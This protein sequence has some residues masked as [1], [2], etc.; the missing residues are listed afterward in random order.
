MGQRPSISTYHKIKG[1]K[2]EMPNF[3][4]I[5]QEFRES[6][7]EKFNLEGLSN[8]EIKKKAEDDPVIFGYAYIGKKV[9]LHQAYIM[10]KFVQAMSRGRIRLALC[11]ARQ[12]GKTIGA[13]ILL[14]WLCWYNKIPATIAN[15]TIWYVVS[16]DD[17]TA[18]ELLGKIRMLLYEGDIHML[19][20][21]IEGFFT[22]SIKEPNNT[23]QITFLN[24]CFIKSVPPTK[25]ILGKSGNLWIDEAHRLNCTDISTEDFFDLASAITAE[26]KGAIVLS[27]SPEGIVGFFHRAID[28]DGQYEENE[29]DSIWWDHTIWDDDSEECKNYKAH[30]EKERIRLTAAGRYKMFQQEHGALFTVTEIA[31]F[32][33]EDIDNN[34]EDVPNLSEYDEACA[35]GIDYGLKN[36]RT[37]ITVRAKVKDIIRQIFQW[38]SPADFDINLL[39]DPKFEHSIPRLKMRY[40]KMFMIIADDCP[41]GDTTNRWIE[42]ESGIE[43]KKYNFRSDQM[44]KTDGINRNC[45]A[46]SYRAALKMGKLLIPKWNTTQQFEMKT[47]QEVEQKVLISIKAPQGQL[48]DTF[49]SDMMA[50]LPFLDMQNIRDFQV[51]SLHGDDEEPNNSSPRVDK[52]SFKKMTD[53]QCRQLIA[54]ANEGLVGLE[55]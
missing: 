20:Y 32:D 46:Y 2:K 36:A 18:K 3:T 27:S 17:D 13:C 42:S 26:T 45:L 35:A 22:G 12:L 10:H 29:Y 16:R 37:V 47:V 15:V 23:E 48:C 30:V 39:K 11:L 7:K 54:D 24:N 44:S 53:E 31:F 14:I 33:H 25:K 49:D 8:E 5:P 52:S 28:P 40:P 43:L 19:Q 1:K 21:E 50:S 6:Y 4:K 34:L 51:D 9:R 55:D 41:A 38:R